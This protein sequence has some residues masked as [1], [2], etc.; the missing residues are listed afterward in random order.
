MI[1][2]IARYFGYV[3]LEISEERILRDYYIERIEYRTN[4]EK[5]SSSLC[6]PSIGW[7]RYYRSR[8]LALGLSIK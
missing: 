4:R 7:V 8:L 2:F 5:E 3:K 6:S 1:R